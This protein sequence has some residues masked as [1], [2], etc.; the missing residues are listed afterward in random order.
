MV[1]VQSTAVPVVTE[2]PGRTSPF[3]VSEVRARVDGIVRKRLFSEGQEVQA[4]KSLYEIDPAPYQAALGSALAQQKKAEANVTVTV[5][6]E[7]RSQTLV[8]GNAI[9][10][11]AYETAVAARQQ[12]EADLAAA[13][14]AVQVARLNLSYTRVDAPIAGRTSVSQVTQGAYVQAGAATLLTTVQQIDPIYV[15]LKEPSVDGLRL[16]RALDAGQVSADALGRLKVTLLLEDGTA[17]ALPGKLQY[18]GISVDPATGAVSLRA[19]FPNPRGVLLPGMFVRARVE[20]GVN[21]DALLVP[22]V[23]VSH[24][25]QGEATTLV[26][27]A[28]NVVRQRVLATA[29]LQGTN[30]VVTGG[31]RPGERV[32]VSNLQQIH[33]GQQVRPAAP[34]PALAQ[35]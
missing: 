32:A 28:G 17:Y 16:R 3:L 25:P 27:D 22:A 10:K 13:R 26:V 34:G 15:D 5:A 9:S 1:T 33:P 14:A 35:H 31:L 20:Q 6:Q 21:P 8:N 12:A 18:T 29:G 23:A 2:L 24:D 7:L 19:L 4:G 11:Q 30:W